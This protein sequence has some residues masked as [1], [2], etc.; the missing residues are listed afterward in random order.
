MDELEERYPA[1][2][3][4]NLTFET[5]E[6]ILKHCSRRH[7]ERLEQNAAAAALSLSADTEDA[8]GQIFAPGAA[9]GTRYPQAHLDRLMI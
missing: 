9:A 1:C 4:L 5:R 7:A 8:L 6:G 3:G 2:D